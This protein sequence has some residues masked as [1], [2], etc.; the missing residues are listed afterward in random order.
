[1]K[2]IKE[3]FTP[4]IDDI[5]RSMDWVDKAYSD[6]LDS[7]YALDYYLEDDYPD[8]DKPISVKINDLREFGSSLYDDLDD[9][10]KELSVDDEGIEE[11]MKVFKE[12]MGEDFNPVN[13]R[14][15]KL[16]DAIDDFYREDCG[17]T[18]YL[19]NN[20]TIEDLLKQAGASEDDSD[21]MEGF[22]VTISTSALVDIFNIIRRY[23]L[24][25]GD[26]YSP[27]LMQEFRLKKSWIYDESLKEDLAD[28]IQKVHDKDEYIWNLHNTDYS[29]LYN[30]LK[31]YLKDGETFG[32]RDEEGYP[33]DT[34]V[35]IKELISR[36]P[37]EK[38]VDVLVKLVEP[39]HESLKESTLTEKKW[40]YTLQSGKA[41][42]QA[43]DDEDVERVKENLK[44][45]WEE[46]HKQFPDDF[47]EYELEDKI[48][49]IDYSEDDIDEVDYQLDDL[50]DFC[51]AMS[52][53]VE[54]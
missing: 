53:W 49:E 43:I 21:E 46:I 10:K 18:H 48:T 38:Q 23:L 4:N 5:I 15:N 16:I 41:L 34:N 50:Y 20:K 51:D 54:L 37:R 44:K 13:M 33:S 26:E 9:I 7:L 8:L 1:M 3:S 24:N 47:D 11:N 14:R 32:A 40:D 17:G 19:F 30:E 28:Y 6:L 12:S 31:D 35:G 42:R 39:F 2:I 22:Y 29:W 36:M 25:H 27:E 52:I 45:C